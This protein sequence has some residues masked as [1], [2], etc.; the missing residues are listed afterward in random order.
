MKKCV[1][2]PRS[3]LHNFKVCDMCY[4]EWNNKKVEIKKLVYSL[5]PPAVPG[6]INHEAETHIEKLT[7]YFEQGETGKYIDHLNQLKQDR[8]G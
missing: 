6:M 5:Y 2:C 7:C 8:N 1:E 4:K 3:K